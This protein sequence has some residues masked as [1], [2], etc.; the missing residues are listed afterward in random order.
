MINYFCK[1]FKYLTLDV[2]PLDKNKNIWYHKAMK[3]RILI[4]QVDIERE[5][6][7]MNFKQCY[8][9]CL[10]VNDAF[11]RHIFIIY[12][13]WLHLGGD[14]FVCVNNIIIA[15]Y[16]TVVKRTK[17]KMF[18]GWQRNVIFVLLWWKKSHYY[19]ICSQKPFTNIKKPYNAWFFYSHN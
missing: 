12:P 18:S 15:F 19:C 16:K 8:Q 4:Y 9:H 1:Y 6:S 10:K 14:N 3:I 11:F 13:C 17:E 7:L 2:L 5:S